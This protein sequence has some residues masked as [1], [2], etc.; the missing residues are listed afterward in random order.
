MKPELTLPAS[1][2]FGIASGTSYSVYGKGLPVVL[3]HGVGMQ[4]TI[5]APQIN[6]LAERYQVIVYDM[7]GHG[8]SELPSRDVTLSHYAEQL[9]RLLDHL[10]VG[11]AVVVGHSMGALVALE[12]ALN[13]PERT[14]KVVALNAV[15]CRSPG[16]RRSIM[17]RI[18]ALNEVGITATLDSTV[19]R[20]FGDSIPATLAEEAK[21][22][23]SLL[24]EANPIGYVRSYELFASHDDTHTRTL[25]QLAVPTLFMTGEL[26]TNSSPAMSKAMAQAT[27]NSHLVVIPGE[28]HMMCLT[29]AAI[30]NRHLVD[31]IDSAASII[32]PI[33]LRKALSSFVTGVTIV[34]TIQ[35]DGTQRGFTANSFTSVSL[36]PALI[37]VCVGKGASSY[38]VFSK[39]PHFCVS[40]L[41]EHQKATSGIFASKSANKFEQVAWHRGQT[42]SP[43]IDGSVAWFDCETHQVIDAGDHLI[44]LGKVMDFAH[45]SA[46]PLGYCRGA[47]VPFSLSQDALAVASPH[48]RVGAILEHQGGIVFLEAPDKVF[49]LPTGSKLEPASDPKSLRGLLSKLQ[50]EAQLDFLFAV[51]EETGNSDGAVHIYYRGQTIGEL[52]DNRAI[53]VMPLDAIPW[54]KLPDSAVS[55]ML[56]RYV[57]ERSEDAF[58][59]YVGDT[60]TG[61]VRS[62]AYGC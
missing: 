23:R 1:F 22:A 7:L 29:A 27:P 34:S 40:V 17:Q 5:W 3:I 49:H 16:Q 9:A 43:V 62:L 48:A 20:W 44:L 32:N 58:G 53:H 13:F 52:P 59:V 47:Y 10:G 14:S 2:D 8:A 51:F 38:P 36:E 61:S 54:P 30:V 37:L 12:F 11:S 39:T 24:L 33:E 26:D 35:A 18:D 45:S 46:S 4:Q 50:I 41:A 15:Y 25:S 28:R 55:S 21:L 56:Q 19:A 6:V 42:G 57:K 60:N 31:F